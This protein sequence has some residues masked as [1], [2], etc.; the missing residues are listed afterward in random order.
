MAASG[1]SPLSAVL[2]EARGHLRG[3]DAPAAIALL[4]DLPRG[5]DAN[6]ARISALLGQAYAQVGSFD[7]ADDLLDGAAAVAKRLGDA[8]LSSD[9][10][11]ARAMRRLLEHKPDAARELLPQVRGTRNEAGQLRA[12]HLESL[13]LQEEGRHRDAARMLL[14]LLA[15]VDPNRSTN[16]ELRADAT[17]AL[18]NL[19]RELY[20]PEAL[21]E[22]ERQLG[23]AAWP[24]VYNEQR[25]QALRALGW[26]CALRGDYFNAFRLLRQCSRF[27]TSDVW[28]AIAAAERAELARCKGEQLWSRQELAEAEEHAS[29]VDWN[30]VRGDAR[31][32]LLLLAELFVPIDG[33]R[34]AYYRAQFSE[35]DQR[36]TP[37]AQYSAGVVDV[38]LGHEKLGADM[39]RKSL[40]A[41]RAQGY[42]WRAGRSALRLFEVT[43]NR[44]DLAIASEHL[45]HYMNSWLGDELRR[46]S[47]RRVALP[48]MQRRVYDA[49]CRGLSN[50]EI[51]REL[52]RSEFTIRNHIKLI[53][54]AFGVNSRAEL[55]A[56]HAHTAGKA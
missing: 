21:P 8:S 20:I 49:L 5:R 13:I 36:V 15:R 41:F 24:D 29:S 3:D 53:F 33:A 55:I 16:M 14:Q 56:K 1:E 42:D 19:A 11:H 45:R 40:D 44:G 38:A 46:L 28:R 7:L 27:A 52:G 22:V 37:F 50:A 35:W 43:R 9:V 10:A 34:A 39:L 18:A 54:K 31:L 26:A 17:Y 30:A 25:F 32:G 6:A 4:E 2:E 12:L 48:P 23:G 47:E 51:A